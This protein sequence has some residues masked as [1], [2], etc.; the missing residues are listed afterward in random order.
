[1]KK[2][3]FN[4]GDKLS[5]SFNGGASSRT[6]GRVKITVLCLFS[7]RKQHRLLVLGCYLAVNVFGSAHC[8]QDGTVGYQ[9]MKLR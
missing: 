3:H 8:P 1:M 2:F 4:N 9:P 6:K 7:L 5:I